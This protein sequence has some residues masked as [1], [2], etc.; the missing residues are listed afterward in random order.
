MTDFIQKTMGN[1]NE[2]RRI[3]DRL[4]TIADDLY[5][6]GL[7]RASTR[8]DNAAQ[9]IIRLAEEA[10]SAIGAKCHDDAR[11]ATEAINN[12]MR[13]YLTSAFDLEQQS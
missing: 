9:E 7:E 10:T 3:A 2:I 6:V 8:V 1:V 5:A 13:A 11:A 12:M 4:I